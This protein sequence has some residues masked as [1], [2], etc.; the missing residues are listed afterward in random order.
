MSLAL[1]CDCGGSAWL[2]QFLFGSPL[3]G[4]LSQSHCYPTKLEEASKNPVPIPKLFNT[5]ASRFRDRA[6]K[7]G[8]KNANALWS[9]ALEQCEKGWLTRPFPLC[10]KGRPFVLENSKLNIAFL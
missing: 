7:S 8:F 1:Q 4:R 3:V 10:S 9:E 6:S 5:N 2:Q